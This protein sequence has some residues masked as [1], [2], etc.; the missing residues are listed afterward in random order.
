[1]TP[2]ELIAFAGGALMLALCIYYWSIYH[3]FG[4]R[5]DRETALLSGGAS[6]IFFFILV[7]SAGFRLWPVLKVAVQS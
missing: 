3:T 1:M 5:V 4:G 2:F 6:S 7:A